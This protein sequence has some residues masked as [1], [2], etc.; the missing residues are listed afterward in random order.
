M[1]REQ[2]GVCVGVPV[3]TLSGL[4]WF[5]VQAPF[6]PAIALAPF[7][8]VAAAFAAVLGAWRMAS[9]AW[10][11]CLMALYTPWTY[12]AAGSN[13]ADTPAMVAAAGLALLVDWL[14]QA[15]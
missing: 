15:R 12:G 5:L 9:L 10:L 2:I 7:L 1:T 4:V 13:L 11:F 14:W 3:L 8:A 6:T